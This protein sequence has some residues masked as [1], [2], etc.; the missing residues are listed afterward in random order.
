MV[1]CP[2]CGTENTASRLQAAAGPGQDYVGEATRR[3]TEE[4]IAH[5]EAGDHEL[6]GKTE[7][8]PLWRALR[9]VSGE[10]TKATAV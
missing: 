7:P 8:V 4:T 6:E 1:V 10:H 3:A 9:V 5:E 2:N